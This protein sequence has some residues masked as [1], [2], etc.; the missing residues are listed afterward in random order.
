MV[1]WWA[2]LVLAIAGAFLVEPLARLVTDGWWFG[3]LGYAAVFRTTL[4]AQA[5]LASIAGA[6]AFALVGGSGR[7]AARHGEAARPG[8]TVPLGRPASI[9]SPRRVADGVTALIA[10]VS[11]LAAWSSWPTAAMLAYG[12]SMGWTDP[13]WGLDAGFYVFQLPALVGL[14]RWLLGLCLAALIVAAATYVGSG[15]VR[16]QLAQ[17]DGQLVATG[18]VWPTE[19][20][21]HL[22]S[23][24]AVGLVLLSLRAFLARYEAM[25]SVDGLFAGPGY[26]DL[27]GAF[28]AMTVEAIGLALAAFAGF[29]TV[30]RGSVRGFGAVAAAVVGL[31][32]LASAAP[33]V[34]QEL[35]VQP[36][37]LSREGPQIVHHLAATRYAFDLGSVDEEPLTGVPALEPADLDRNRATI[38]NVCLWDHAPLLAAFAQ[39]Q[40]I[41]TYYGFRSVDND[42][43]TIDG[44]LR[45]V[46]L[47]P[48]ELTVETLPEQARTWV[49]ETTTYTHGYG[50][51]LG[52]VNEVTTQGLPELFVKDVPPKVSTPALRIDRPE[53]YFGEGLDHDVIVNTANPEFDYPSGDD[54]A[55]TRY[56]GEDGVALGGVGRAW[57]ALRMGAS[58]VVLSGDLRADS[59]VLM[60]RDIVGRAS[61]IA[62]M[63]RF[64]SDPYLVVDQGRLVWILDAYTTS[65]DFPY[66]AHVDGFGAYARNSVKVTIDA[67]DGTTT[68]WRTGAP[69]PI[70]D[71]W[72]RVFPGLFRPIDQLPD[73]LRAHLRYP[74]DLFT[75]QATLFATY[76]M[77]DPQV[78]YNR[79]DEWE[80]PAVQ[81]R[82]MTPYYTV[83]KLP[84]EDR[85][86]FLLMLPFSPRGKPNLAAWMV[87]RSDREHYGQLRVYKFPKDTMVYG[88]A[89]VVARINQDDAISEKLSL[90]NQQG[91]Q[92]QLGTLMVIPVEESLIYVQPL[93]LRAS[94]GS[95]PELKRVIVAY[96]DRIA[97]AGTLQEGLV[98]LFGPGEPAPAAEPGLAVPAVTSAE[99]IRLAAMHWEAA[100][101]AAARG[102]WATWGVHEQALGELIESLAASARSTPAPP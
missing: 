27:Y 97:M 16:V 75:A 32:L 93:Y 72:G 13:V 47:S 79:E 35:G 24:V 18:I 58:E 63:L 83:M 85:E 52:P 43:Y 4:L 91:S 88:P 81:Q 73:S 44:R 19:V 34:V 30:D 20:K 70:A 84:G 3:S 99:L 64:D 23:L 95:I 96:Q 87:A 102:D 10:L 37:E 89:M 78:F 15:T 11:A 46:V 80:V 100:Q 55:Y 69:D 14:V 77:Q 21:R 41:R 26:A 39:V 57:F 2:L 9:A 40:E 74:E 98:E 25:S 1:P 49:N 101:Q 62:P 33:A 28:P 51:A 68:F 5:A 36:N 8:R 53:L 56:E 17:Q 94:S 76:H 29:V 61:R 92:V 22:A 6:L 31:R 65:D 12:G 7:L 38:D 82:R 54:N 67:Y 42:R 66:A 86:E 71:A 90:W 59:R 50:I 48:R 45:Q 60:Y